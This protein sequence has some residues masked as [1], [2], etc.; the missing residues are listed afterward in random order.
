MLLA[1]CSRLLLA[2]T[3]VGTGCTP[4]R[5]TDTTELPPAP[6]QEPATASGGAA[7]QQATSSVHG[8]GVDPETAPPNGVTLAREVAELV[9]VKTLPIERYDNFQ[10]SGLL[11]HEGR[12]LT[13]SDKHEDQ[14]FELMLEEQ[15][16][17]VSSYRR[18]ALPQGVVE[19][20]LE[21]LCPD[22][23]GGLFLAS[24]AQVRVLRLASNAA[25]SWATPSLEPLGAAVGLFALPNAKLEGIA[26]LS[27]GRILV[28]AERSQRGLI[29]I[30]ADGDLSRAHA[31]SMPR[32]AFAL[33]HGRTP[34]F[35]DLA[36]FENELFALVRSAHL[37]V[38][39]QRSSAGWVE[40]EAWSFAVTENDDRFGYLDRRYGIAEGLAL[41]GNR[42]YVVFDNNGNGRT[43]APED[44]RPQLM[45]FERP[46]R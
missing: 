8:R 25:L 31:W 20:D 34:D 23:E 2:I 3:L 28:A 14:I 27:D 7:A 18:F 33:P 11:W 22:G 16:V 19:L 21:G 29:E 10:P 35:S 9:L 44:V 12:L 36:S 4:S 26:R 41:D 45:I 40:G 17:T 39:L 38:E 32:S 6:P 37:V 30:P 15:R 46:A 24:E 43:S 42:V 5:R 1:R 13:V